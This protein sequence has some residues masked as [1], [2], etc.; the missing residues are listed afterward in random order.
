MKRIATVSLA[1]ALL[2][3][4]MSGTAEAR[5]LPV[6]TASSCTITG[7]ISSPVDGSF[8]ISSV[9]ISG[10]WAGLR[11]RV[12]QE[13]YLWFKMNG[14]TSWGG[15]SHFLDYTTTSRNSGD[16]SDTVTLTTYEWYH[17][18]TEVKVWLG[19][20]DGKSGFMSASPVTCTLPS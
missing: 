8:T 19:V 2:A 4:A 5:P 7:S 3:L 6:V 9:S 13:A 10:D 20:T 15:E 17:P 12:M 16:I 18:V 14:D 1:A 11:T